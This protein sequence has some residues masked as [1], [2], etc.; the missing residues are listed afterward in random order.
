MQRRFTMPERNLEPLMW[1]ESI[2]VRDRFRDSP[3]LK[4]LWQAHPELLH[5]DPDVLASA[6]LKAR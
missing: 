6:R 5:G 1:N 2:G 3:D 4:H